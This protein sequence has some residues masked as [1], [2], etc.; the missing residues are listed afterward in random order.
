MRARVSM[1]LKVISII[2]S[3]AIFE[4]IPNYATTSGGGA[5]VNDPYKCLASNRGAHSSPV[6][7]AKSILISNDFY[8]IHPGFMPVRYGCNIIDSKERDC[9]GVPIKSRRREQGNLANIISIGYD[10]VAVTRQ[11]IGSD[12]Y[13]PFERSI[14]SRGLPVIFGR[15]VYG[16]REGSSKIIN[17]LSHKANISAQLPIL[18]IPGS[19][20]EIGS[21]AGIYHQNEDTD[22]SGYKRHPLEGIVLL[23]CGI[24]LAW[25]AIRLIVFSHRS[26]NFA[27]AGVSV[28]LLIAGWAAGSYGVFL[29]MLHFL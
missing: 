10:D 11:W 24:A 7:F 5:F 17:P 3:I 9:L 8:N 18:C 22:N 6:R 16:D 19:P 1:T 15:E 13:P 12:S 20:C 26:L 27:I 28:G 25:Y 23:C 4:K 29:L 21:K 2:V 14:K